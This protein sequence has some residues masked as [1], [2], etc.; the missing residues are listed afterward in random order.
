MICFILLS[1]T[2][3][4]RR[5]HTDP[6]ARQARRA[7]GDLL[8]RLDKSK[9]RATDDHP[10]VCAAVLGAFRQYLGSKLYL[11]PGAL[12][13]NDVGKILLKKGAEK[14][15]LKRLEKLFDECEAGRFAGNAHDGEEPIPLIGRART[16]AL[17]LEGS[18]R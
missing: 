16:L 14:D 11:V 10:E 1:S 8:K 3:I 12:T 17:D 13:F 5:R 18:L 7:Y 4:I 9:G 2:R 15:V 6:A